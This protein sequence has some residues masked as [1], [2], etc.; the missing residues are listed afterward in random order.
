MLLKKSVQLFQSSPLIL[1]S[2]YGVFFIDASSASRAEQGFSAIAE[3]CQVGNSMDEFKRW[4]TNLAEDWLLI[5]D[6]A[7]DPSLDILP[8]F[9]P[10]CRGTI[11][12]T[13][14]NP[15]CKIHATVG[16]RNIGA[17]GR[18]EAIS[19]L[20]KASGE[21]ETD[22]SLRSRALPVVETLW[23]LALAIIQ[24]GAVIRQKLCTFEDYCNAYNIRRKELLTF[25]PVQAG[26]DYKFTVYTTWEVSKE[27]IRDIANKQNATQE[28]RQTA[29]NALELLTFFGFC[30]FDDIW[31]DFFQVAWG[32]LSK[33]SA[34]PWWRPESFQKLLGNRPPER[35][36]FPFRQALSLLSSYSLIQWSDLRVS[37]HPLVHSWIRDSLV[38]EAQLRHWTSSLTN[39]A[40]MWGG[41]GQSYEYHRRLMP[42]VQACLGVRDL[43]YL[44]IDDTLVIERAH[45][46]SYLLDVYSH[47]HQPGELL[48]L[49]ESALE[50]TRKLL[51]DGHDLTWT[52][53]DHNISAYKYLQQYQEII[54]KAET[55]AEDFL[56][57]PSPVISSVT[58]SI[59]SQ[60]MEAYDNLKHTKKAL[61][62]GE[63]LVALCID[64]RGEDDLNTW[65]VMQDLAHSYVG[66]GRWVEAAEL[67]K[68]VIRRQENFL[69]DDD[70]IF[71][72]SKNEL[73]VM[74][75]QMGQ[76]QEAVDILQHVVAKRQIAL[77]DN[78][79]STLGSQVILA[80]AYD[81]LGQPGTGIPLLVHAIGL[82]EKY[83]VP[84][85]ELQF[86]KRR[87]ARS[88]VSEAYL[89][90][91]RRTD[92]QPE[93]VISLLVEAI[94]MGEKTGVADDELRNWKSG[95]AWVKAL[96]AGRLWEKRIEPFQPDALLSLMVS[97]VELGEKGGES[98]EVLQHWRKLIQEWQSHEAS[99]LSE[100][101]LKPS[102]PEPKNRKRRRSQRG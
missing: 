24:A 28:A 5:I 39:L 92:L 93:V 37:L 102:T 68:R 101:Q 91:T 70:P 47:C 69:S 1:S 80:T 31:E 87:L 46:T 9:P 7:D 42:H 40:L 95:L 54:N 58:V 79:P 66:I 71:L 45:I 29:I 36:A 13:T 64:N 60:L 78:H 86:W 90:R 97:A 76:Y 62:L 21:Q 18:E 99:S 51:G 84:D 23:S 75:I 53:M 65:G 59:M 26:S 38:E 96:E 30:H 41:H 3:R 88:R 15:D 89:L 73:A 25:H 85:A 82:G 72:S 11:I 6:N 16:F 98:N 17:M 67:G 94:E 43:K 27:S 48:R 50:Y 44:L 52:F 77:A 2:F 14:R 10:S 56:S 83:G 55:W 61:D 81:G 22:C 34:S 57:S 8:Y 33:L 20:L 35:D 4:L 12:I 63:K 49:S 19:L 74:Y 100:Q 32:K